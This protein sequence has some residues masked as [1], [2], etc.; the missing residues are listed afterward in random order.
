MPPQIY[1]ALLKFD[2]FLFL[3]FEVQFLVIVT[4]TSNFEFYLTVATIPITILLLLLAAWS[5]KQEN[6]YGMIA[7][8]VCLSFRFR[9]GMFSD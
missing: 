5:T 1:I 4:H 7:T 6:I 3:G 9:P 8:I 2:F